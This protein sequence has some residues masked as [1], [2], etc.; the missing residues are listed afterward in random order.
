M[1]E[2]CIG[3]LSSLGEEEGIF[4]SMVLLPWSKE[5][6]GGMQAAELWL[7]CCLQAAWLPGNISGSTFSE[8]GLCKLLKIVIP[9][10]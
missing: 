5:V 6:K 9:K 2:V 8:P 7:G 4:S 1:L 10:L 3:I